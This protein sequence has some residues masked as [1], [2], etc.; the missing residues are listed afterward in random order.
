MAVDLVPA[1]KQDAPV[2]ERLL[3]L[4]SH[5]L[6]DLANLRIG[7]DGRFGYAHLPRYWVEPERHPYLLK[8]EGR[9]RHLA[10]PSGSMGSSRDGAQ[11]AGAGLLATGGRHVRGE[12]GRA[13][14]C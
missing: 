1:L 12:A 5:D 6:S 9:A 11:H 3:E 4:Y 8:V 2:L 7:D 10:R 13:G 14:P